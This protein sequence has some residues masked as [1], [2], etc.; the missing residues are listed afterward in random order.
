MST[1]RAIDRAI[2]SEASVAERVRRWRGEFDRSFA[3]PRRDER[4]G[5]GEDF[6]GLRLGGQPHA[7]RLAELAA[8][9]GWQEPAPYPLAP[10]ALL[11][12]IGHRDR[13]LPLFDLQ[14]LLGLGRATGPTWQL[15]M[16]ERPLALAVDGFDGQWRLPPAAVI[17]ADGDAD[18]GA[19]AGTGAGELLRCD[20]A[21]RP[22]IRLAA[23]AARLEHSSTRD[24]GGT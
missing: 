10:P 15:I 16:R 8:L 13:V 20:G 9:Q 3:E 1:D 21:L 14:A 5:D 19:D 17:R 7:L 11:G 4:A 18:A 23:L 2:A 22:L 12:L 24:W 6:L